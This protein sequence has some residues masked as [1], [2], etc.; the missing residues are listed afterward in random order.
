MVPSNPENVCWGQDWCSL[1]T[2]RRKSYVQ[3]SEYSQYYLLLCTHYVQ[4]VVPTLK[5]STYSQ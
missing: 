2:D 5:S 1:D 3:R 4:I